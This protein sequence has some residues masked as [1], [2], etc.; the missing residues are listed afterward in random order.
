MAAPAYHGAAIIWLYYYQVL[1]RNQEGIKIELQKK[2]HRRVCVWDITFL[3]ARPPFY[4]ILCCFL[5]LLPP[6]S[7]VTNLINGPYKDT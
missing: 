5:R 7:Q 2:V 4:V 6:P 3:T 1:M